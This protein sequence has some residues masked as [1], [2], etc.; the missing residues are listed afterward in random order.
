MAPT[1]RA[2]ARLLPLTRCTL[3]IEP[4]GSNSFC[5][6]RRRTHS[7]DPGHQRVA[8]RCRR[9]PHSSTVESVCVRVPREYHCTGRSGTHAAGRAPCATEAAAP[10]SKRCMLLRPSHCACCCAPPHSLSSKQHVATRGGGG[11]APTNRRVKW[12]WRGRRRTRSPAAV[13]RTHREHRPCVR[14]NAAYIRVLMKPAFASAV[15]PKPKRSLSTSS[16]QRMRR[17]G[18]RCNRTTCRLARHDSPRAPAGPDPGVWRAR[19]TCTFKAA[20]VRRV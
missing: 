15:T 20:R 11:G 19:F 3:I 1:Q 2:A 7:C 18:T 9:D 16:E 17:S 12:S 13:P 8:Q 6:K 4:Y 10:P 14:H 5:T